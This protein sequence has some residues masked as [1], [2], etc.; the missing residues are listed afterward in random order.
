[1]FKRLVA[2]VL[3]TA[4]AMGGSSLGSVASAF[5]PQPLP[6]AACNQGTAIPWTGYMDNVIPHWKDWDGDG[7]FACYHLNPTYPPGNAGME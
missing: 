4:A 1:M 5:G 6:D 2:T 7:T 3:L